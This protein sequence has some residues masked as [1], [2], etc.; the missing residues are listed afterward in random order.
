MTVT[1]DRLS[2]IARSLNRLHWQPTADE[3]AF[4]SAFFE[5]MK[6]A[7]EEQRSAFP[8]GTNWWDRLHTESF[9]TLARVVAMV[10]DELLPVWRERLTGSPMV[11]LAELYVSAAEP[12]LP[13]A[14]RLVAAWGNAAPPSP[15]A[16]EI[17]R[18]AGR[19]NLSAGLAERRI[20]FENA[21][22]WEEEGNPHGLWDDLRPA[23]ANVSAVRSTMMAAVTGDTDY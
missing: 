20:R 11:E 13:H 21:S 18:E 23:W 5:R 9:A 12:L 7:E 1:S 16:D 22:H 6:E 2:E 3:V 8:R 14:E 4:G 19:L 10:Q 17:A 15:T